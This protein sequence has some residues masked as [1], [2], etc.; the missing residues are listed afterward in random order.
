MFL[1]FSSKKVQ[2]SA[3]YFFQ[4]AVSPGATASKSSCVRR[5][6][7]SCVIPFLVPQEVKKISS[8]PIA[9]KASVNFPT[10]FLPNISSTRSHRRSRKILVSA[11]SPQ[12]VFPNVI[13]TGSVLKFP[14]RPPYRELAGSGGEPGGAFFLP[15][16][17]SGA[18]P[19]NR[20]CASHRAASG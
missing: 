7:S 20:C 12:T 1:P 2:S 4:G 6:N 19:G 5:T 9:N 13:S 10:V 17:Q 16:Q 8:T 11:P 15:H 18:A 3:K 14:A